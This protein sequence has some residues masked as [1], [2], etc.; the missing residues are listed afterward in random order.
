DIIF[1]WVARMIMMGIK[2]MGD[3][4]FHEVYIHGLV[5]DG[6][7]Q[8]MSKS[9]GNVLDPIDV[10]DGIELDELLEKRC[11]A[12]MQPKMAKRIEKLTRKNFP[13]GISAFGTDALR[14]TFAALA[15]TGRDVTLTNERIE[16]YRNFCNK[17]WNASLYVL[18]NTEEH[19]CGQ[20][21]GEIELNSA[22]RWIKSRL[23]RTEKA[24]IQAFEQYRFDLAA[25]ACYDFIWNEYCSWYLELSKS[26]LYN[27]DSSEAQLRGTR[28][29]LVRVLETILRLVHPLIPFISEEI[30]QRIAPLAGKQGETIMLQPYPEASEALIDTAAETDMDWLM[31]FVLGIRRIRSG[32]NIEP[33]KLLPVLLQNASESD[34]NKLTAYRNML[35]SIARIESIQVL[36]NDE[37]APESAT[38][39]VGEMKILIPM[40]GLIDKDAE[41]KRLDKEIGKLESE[42]SNGIA[43]LGNE[44]FVS[45]APEQVVNKHRQH[46][47]ELALALKKLKEQR[48]KI[49]AI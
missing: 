45:R 7:G 46:V 36:S 24:V 25:Q 37:P 40:A 29:T 43:K 32:M 35:S 19:D 17:L 48:A 6:E 11:S 14:F 39:L 38:A 42:H 23:Q 31:Q 1:F 22:D 13:E 41:L 49:A 26:V 44:N 16:G 34:Q 15:T 12:L 8:K 2:F 28:F 10:I 18:M 9:K 47:E 27:D 4:P 21:G 3:V 33:R 30:W 5:R 20:N